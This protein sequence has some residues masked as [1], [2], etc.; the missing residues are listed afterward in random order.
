MSGRA[1]VIDGVKLVEA[2]P[3]GPLPP[4]VPANAERCDIV[5][6]PDLDPGA[7]RWFVGLG[8]AG[9]AVGVAAT[10]FLEFWGIPL[11]LLS[12]V[13][14]YHGLVPGTKTVVTPSP[15]G[16]W[17]AFEADPDEARREEPFRIELFL[18]LVGLAIAHRIVDGFVDRGEWWWV[19]L[20]SIVIVVVFHYATR[21]NEWDASEALA[22]LRFRAL[23]DPARPLDE[24]E[25]RNRLQEPARTRVESAGTGEGVAMKGSD[26][27]QDSRS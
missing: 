6:V 2:E 15:R 5:E 16:R 10:A 1:R 19:V 26:R 13:S 9:L 11:A 17:L 25:D 18:L 14:L 27:S 4:G 22:A 21:R 20:A 23:A 12:L 8:A 3:G 7:K 24:G